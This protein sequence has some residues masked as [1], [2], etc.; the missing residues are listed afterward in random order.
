MELQAACSWP[1]PWPSR[2]SSQVSVWGRPHPGPQP[3]TCSASVPRTPHSGI[4]HPHSH[5]AS[6]TPHPTTPLTP[7]HRAPHVSG[8]WHLRPS[9]TPQCPVWHHLG[10]LCGALVHRGRGSRPLLTSAGSSPECHAS[11]LL[12]GLRRPTEHSCASAC[13]Y[14]RTRYMDCF[15]PLTFGRNMGQ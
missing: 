8:T 15:L 7:R 13:P 9:V 2:P 12:P 6:R 14:W 4:L 10:A 11:Q 5:L 1:A 3:T